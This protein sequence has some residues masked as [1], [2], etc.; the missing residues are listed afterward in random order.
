[1]HNGLGNW[2]ARIQYTCVRWGPAMFFVCTR[3][4]FIRTVKQH[5]WAMGHSNLASSCICIG[6]VRLHN[7]CHLYSSPRQPFYMIYYGCRPPH[8][9]AIYS[10]A[11]HSMVSLSI[12]PHSDV[13][14]RGILA[15][16]QYPW[17]IMNHPFYEIQ[18]LRSTGP[19]PS[20]QWST[21]TKLLT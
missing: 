11:L 5:P 1:M 20:V 12:V 3:E 6:T 14:S 13:C 18:R 19:P 17:I 7:Y 8:F 15:C 10:D 21:A 9:C 2:A 16:L 4:Y